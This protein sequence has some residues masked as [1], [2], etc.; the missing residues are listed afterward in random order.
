MTV[1]RAS[2]QAARLLTVR[3]WV[4]PA[5]SSVRC[6]F[7]LDMWRPAGPWLAPAIRLSTV[8]VHSRQQL[9][10]RGIG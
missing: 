1:Q 5:Q 8:Y 3:P 6:A 4:V 9:P 2:A 7:G 10:G